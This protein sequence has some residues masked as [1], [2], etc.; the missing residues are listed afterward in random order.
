MRRHSLGSQSLPSF[1]LIILAVC[2]SI[3]Q[4]LLGSGFLLQHLSPDFLN[5]SWVPGVDVQS[6]KKECGK[7]AFD[8]EKR[9]WFDVVTSQ[10]RWFLAECWLAYSCR[11][12]EQEFSYSSPWVKVQGDGFVFLI[13]DC[14][15]FT[16]S[17]IF[18]C[19]CPK[20]LR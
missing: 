18:S 13:R 2:P 11:P 16:L 10:L 12:L 3:L 9:L 19:P 5:D 17:F 4:R 8:P 6:T 20:Y 7:C 14:F 1:Y 15:S